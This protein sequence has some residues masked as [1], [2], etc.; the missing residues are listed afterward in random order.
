VVSLISIIAV[1]SLTAIQITS[2]SS[3]RDPD[4]NP[5]HGWS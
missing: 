4:D 5:W 3:T 2:S 1:N